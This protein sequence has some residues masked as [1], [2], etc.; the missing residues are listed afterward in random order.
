MHTK[1]FRTHIYFFSHSTSATTCSK[2]QWARKQRQCGNCLDWGHSRRSCRRQPVSSG[3]KERAC[4][5][6][7]ERVGIDVNNEEGSDSD[8]STDSDEARDV[9]VVESGDELS[10]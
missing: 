8:D 7:A 2:G 6:H 4:D 10:D 3:R 9:I 1:I 5:W